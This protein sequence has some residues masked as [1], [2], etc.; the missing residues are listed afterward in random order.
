MFEFVIV[1]ALAVVGWLAW[2]AMQSAAYAPKTTSRTEDEIL[3]EVE[4]M[5]VALTRQF[6]QLGDEE[7]SQLVR[8]DLVNHRIKD[9]RAFKWASADTV[10]RLRRNHA[11]AVMTH[12]ADLATK[13]RAGSTKRAKGG[14]SRRKLSAPDGRPAVEV[15]DGVQVTRLA[16][17]PSCGTKNR[18]D[19]KS[20]RR[21]GAT[22]G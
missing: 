15:I 18:G 1:A 6:P 16:A 20:C 14:G 17:C 4:N 9:P 11:R 19:A 3:S 7:I 2:K 13:E 5:A 12:V 22:L 10:G 8:D 21:C